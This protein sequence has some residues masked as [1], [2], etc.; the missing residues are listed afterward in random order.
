MAS[1]PYDLV[2]VGPCQGKVVTQIEGMFVLEEGLADHHDG[3]VVEEQVRH[4]VVEGCEWLLYLVSI[5]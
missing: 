5:H 1:Q 4:F 3:P 2:S